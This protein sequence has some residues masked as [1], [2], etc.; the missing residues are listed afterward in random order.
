MER[1]GPESHSFE[2]L[3]HGVKALQVTGRP[4]NKHETS[5]HALEAALMLVHQIAS[6]HAIPPQLPDQVQSQCWRFPP[7]LSRII[8]SFLLYLLKASRLHH[9]FFHP[10][11]IIDPERSRQQTLDHRTDRPVGTWA[12]QRLLH[13]G[14]PELVGT[15]VG[16]WPNAIWCML[17]HAN[18]YELHSPGRMTHNHQD[19]N[20]G[21]HKNSKTQQKMPSGNNLPS[22]VSANAFFH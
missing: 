10:Q 18:H 8:S 15:E 7:C 4:C 12:Y 1:V 20:Y 21:M 5:S 2:A 6:R 19:D 14:L 17:V 13:H 22:T 16:C 3:P 11:S 9:A